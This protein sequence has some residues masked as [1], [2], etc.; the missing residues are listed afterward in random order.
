MGI[1]TR[2]W[3]R[4]GSVSELKS[5]AGQP[6]TASNPR[7]M[8]RGVVVQ[9]DIYHYANRYELNKKRSLPVG[10]IAFWIVYQPG[11][12]FSPSANG[13]ALSEKCLKCIINLAFLLDHIIQKLLMLQMLV[14]RH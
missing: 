11:V 3:S 14:G 12:T 10:T 2:P 6:V 5:M 8:R 9:T 4:R 13:F 7:P 1:Q